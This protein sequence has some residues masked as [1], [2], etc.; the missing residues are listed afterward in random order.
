MPE[1]QE[2]KHHQ[3]VVWRD[4]PTSASGTFVP[5][6]YLQVL[7]TRRDGHAD[8]QHRYPQETRDMLASLTN[9]CTAIKYAHDR[10]VRRNDRL[11][12]AHRLLS[13]QYQQLAQELSA[14]AGRYRSLQREMMDMQTDALAHEAIVCRY[15]RRLVA[16]E[17]TVSRRGEAGGET[18]ILL[19]KISELQEEKA[20]MHMALTNA[21]ELLTAF[22]ERLHPSRRLEWRTG[23][24]G[25]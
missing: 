22:H 8:I 13:V 19:A 25:P 21:S 20:D 5:R 2:D 23:T 11:V 14:L 1:R 15:E 17:A 12:E 4:G 18:D 3:R 9:R 7:V 6:C 24:M 16:Q 10:A